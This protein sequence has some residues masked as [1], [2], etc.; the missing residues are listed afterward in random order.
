MEAITITYDRTTGRLARG[1]KK[2]GK[3]SSTKPKMFEYDSDLVVTVK[4]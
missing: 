3:I 4:N 1:E 2:L